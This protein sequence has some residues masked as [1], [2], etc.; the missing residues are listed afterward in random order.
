MTPC[1]AAREVMDWCRRRLAQNQQSAFRIPANLTFVSVRLLEERAKLF[2]AD[3]HSLTLAFNRARS[4][5]LP[6]DRLGLS[7]LTTGVLLTIHLTE[8]RR[9]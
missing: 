8:R 3:F 4:A 1:G 9:Q 7:S 2:D 5:P 6:L